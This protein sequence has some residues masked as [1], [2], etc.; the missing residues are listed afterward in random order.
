MG[1][2]AEESKRRGGLVTLAALALSA[3]IPLAAVAETNGPGKNV[4]ASG[5]TKTKDSGPRQ[6][7][8]KGSTAIVGILATPRKPSSGIPGRG[9]K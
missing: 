7:K 2:P 8:I 1:N 9:D 3:A 6:Q 5:T 4:A